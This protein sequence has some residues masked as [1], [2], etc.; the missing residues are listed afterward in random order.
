MRKKVLISLVFSVSLNIPIV[1]FAQQPGRLTAN[2]PAIRGLV[3]EEV[4]FDCAEFKPNLITKFLWKEGPT[5][6]LLYKKCLEQTQDDE[7]FEK[8]NESMINDSNIGDLSNDIKNAQTKLTILTLT[9]A[10]KNY[11]MDPETNED[12]MV[13][14]KNAVENFKQHY[15][16]KK[17][18]IDNEI[19]SMKNKE[20][21]RGLELV[22]II[23]ENET[24]LGENI[25]S[26]IKYME[27]VLKD[28]HAYVAAHNKFLPKI[29][30][31]PKHFLDANL[32]K[33]ECEFLSINIGENW[34]RMKKGLQITCG[35]K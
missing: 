35:K 34:N 9:T 16:E 6:G 2:I 19:K 24:E 22:S 10:L 25:D 21:R 1:A 30:V 28:R 20:N 23:E 4:Q 29:Y 15:V 33:Y 26:T 11:L 5:R 31:D 8:Y 18:L 32:S 14:I 17:S 13:L 12:K 7:K 3:L 27:F